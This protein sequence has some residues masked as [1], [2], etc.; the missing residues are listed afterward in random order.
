MAH[1]KKLA[2]ESTYWNHKGK[3]EDLNAKLRRLVPF[4]G[5]VVNA[6]AHPALERYRVASNYYYD[7][8]NN[9]LGNCREEFELFFGFDALE[10][11]EE[12]TRRFVNKVERAI[13]RIILAAAK[14][15]GL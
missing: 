11:G 12:L 13:D 2:Y 7:L 9:G 10:H 15:Q 5:P 4:Q 3:Y 6:E 8:Y 14:E 1:L